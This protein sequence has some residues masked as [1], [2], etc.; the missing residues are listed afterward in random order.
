MLIP[1]EGL[2]HK[3]SRGAT[4][5][6]PL[7]LS[8]LIPIEGL[9]PAHR[10]VDRRRR[11]RQVLSLLI[12]IEGLKLGVAYILPRFVRVLSLLIPIEGLKLIN[13]YSSVSFYGCVLSLLIPIEG[14]KHVMAM[15]DRTMI[16]CPK[17]AYPD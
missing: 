14:L 15:R 13:K 12:P 17:L 3:A 6:R 1:I 7:V 5:D 2:K 9:K 4:T 11:Q 8:L 10:R 16:S